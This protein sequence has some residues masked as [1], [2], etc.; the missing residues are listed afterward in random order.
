MDVRKISEVGGVEVIGVDLGAQR[1]PE[2]DR[3][4]GAVYDQ[5][6]LVVFR[7]QKLTMQQLVAAGAPFGGTMIDVPAVSKNQDVP[8]C[9]IY[10]TR[11]PNGDV[12]PEDPNALVGDLEWH[13][14]QAY[15][16][17][18][19]RGKFLYGI[20]V[21][22]EGGMTGFVDGQLTYAMLSDDL[23]KRLENLHVIQSWNRAESYIARNRDYRADGA[24]E[25]SYDRFPDMAYPIVVKHPI[26][27]AK[28][29]NFPPLWAAGIVEMP[30]AEGQKLTEELRDY[31]KQPKFQYWHK[32]RVGDAVIWDNWRFIHAASGTPGRYVRTLWKTVIQ[33]GPVFGRILPKVA[34]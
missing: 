29:L 20:E 34:A 5:H 16:A 30:G 31:V 14:D 24:A 27:G 32:Y 4:I 19:N 15:L 7:D 1:T 17:A 6:G 28:V 18:P 33:G 10:S 13:S 25:M 23:K 8:G 9:A 21:P 11:G 3:A 26:T 2:E 22:P 12:I